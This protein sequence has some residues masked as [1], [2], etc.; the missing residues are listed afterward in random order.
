MAE[1]LGPWVAQVPSGSRAEIAEYPIASGQT[2]ALRNMVQRNAAGEVIKLT[3]VDPTPILGFAQSGNETGEI[4][5]AN[6]CLVAL[7]KG[8]VLF[9]MRCSRDPT[10]ADVGDAFGLIENADGEWQVDFADVTATRVTVEQVLVDRKLAL[11][12]V[13]EAHRQIPV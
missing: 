8:D 13:L 5:Y 4:V 3:G 10:Q 9:A 7:A 12:K 2:I 6:N 11:V 1:I